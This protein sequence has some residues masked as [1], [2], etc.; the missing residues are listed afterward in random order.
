MRGLFQINPVTKTGQRLYMVH[1]L[2]LPFLPI[3]ALIIQNSTTLNELLQYQTEVQ[4]IGDKVE[5]AT[6]L[7]RFIT[8][9]QRER[10]EVAFH[11]FTNGTQ[12]LGLNLTDRFKIT[13]EAFEKMTWPNI[14]QSESTEMFKS[15]LRYQV[16]GGREG[17][18]MLTPPLVDQTRRL[19][20][21]D[22]PGRGGH[23]VRPGLV[24]QVNIPHISHDPPLSPQGGRR[25]PGSPL[26]GHPRDQQQ[27]RVEISHCLQESPQIH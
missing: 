21:E 24:Q 19:Q 18:E 23:T 3:T 6:F 11:I 26:P 16:E 1:M 27:R 10:S 15:K 12:T 8:N 9:M 13:D 22:Q 17:R 25:V 7:E 14:K 20:V 2:L 5:T 4:R